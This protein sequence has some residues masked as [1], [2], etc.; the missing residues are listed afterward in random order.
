ML[1]QDSWEPAVA[2][3][4]SADIGLP[5]P[6]AGWLSDTLTQ[7]VASPPA[8]LRL[9]DMAHARSVKW[10]RD[11]RLYGYFHQPELM[12]AVRALIK[13]ARVRSHVE[14]MLLPRGISTAEVVLSTQRAL[15]YAVSQQV[16]DTFAHYFWQVQEWSIGE[17]LEWAEQTKE[18][19]PDHR[20][21]R[22]YAEADAVGAMLREG[23][24]VDNL[25]VKAVYREAFARTYARLRAIDSQPISEETT[26]QFVDVQRVLLKAGEQLV[27]QDSAD[28]KVAQRFSRFRVKNDSRAPIDLPT[29]Q[30]K[31]PVAFK[32]PEVPELMQPKG[33]RRT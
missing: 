33:K 15:G 23:I 9:Y 29:L 8:W 5:P 4:A 6:D 13:N 11:Q 14:K 25:E 30:G 18:T 31:E 3:S 24:G 19:T 2:N 22:E 10:L 16:V 1:L 20:V 28:E 7:P 17:Y 21:R 32:L 27:L 12:D 26:R